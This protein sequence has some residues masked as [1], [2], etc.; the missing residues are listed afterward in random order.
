MNRKIGDKVYRLKHGQELELPNYKNTIKFSNGEEFHV[1][2][3]V[4]YMR[5]VPVAPHLHDSILNWI[6]DNPL[7]FIND[8]RQ[9]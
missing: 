5:G 4:L 7:L 1:I 3:N 9:F 2:N 8:T 6:L